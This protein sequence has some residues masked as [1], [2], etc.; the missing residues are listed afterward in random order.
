MSEFLNRFEPDPDPDMASIRRIWQT[1][2]PILSNAVVE[3]APPYPEYPKMKMGVRH[4]ASCDPS[5]PSARKV[6]NTVEVAIYS[7]D[8]NGFGKAHELAWDFI[9]ANAEAVETSLRQK[10]LAQHLKAKKQFLEE[11]M[12]YVDKAPAYWKQI[13]DK[14]DWDDVSAIEHLYKLVGIGLLD[15]GLDECGFS[16]FEFQSGW[17]RDH[18]ASILMHKQDVLIAGGMSEYTCV[19]SDLIQAIHAVQGYDLDDGDRSLI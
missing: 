18:G 13:Q 2:K 10:L 1:E 3:F 15:T 12:S 14:I 6:G 4:K 8:G 17:D 7:A 19:G 9:I 16:S 5:C 11:D